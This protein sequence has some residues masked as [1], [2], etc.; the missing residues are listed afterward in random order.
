M[1]N[2]TSPASN[3]GNPI[4][5]FV[6]HKVTNTMPTQQTTLSSL[7]RKKPLNSR[8]A[9]KGDDDFPQSKLHFILAPEAIYTKSSIREST[10]TIDLINTQNGIDLHQCHSILN[11]ANCD[12]TAPLSHTSINTPL[13][14]SGIWSNW[15]ASDFRNLV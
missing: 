5:L 6:V 11:G 12:C 15:H 4:D 10:G 2:E 1:V 9:Y 7:S 14:L 8:M 13:P 3:Y